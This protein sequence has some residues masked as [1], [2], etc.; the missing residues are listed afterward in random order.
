MRESERG[1][2]EKEGEREGEGERERERER[3]RLRE[4]VKQ[5]FGLSAPCVWN[6][7][8]ACV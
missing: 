5:L 2:G 3:E 1:G 6:S 7:E 4:F 8:L